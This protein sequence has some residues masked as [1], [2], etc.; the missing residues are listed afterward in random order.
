MTPADVVSRLASRDA[1]RTEADLQADI[2]LLLTSGGL[3]IAPDHVAKLEVPAA[4]G[5]RRRLDV[6]IGHA[7]I[8]VK[9][10]LRAPGVLKDSEVQLAGYVATR[11]SV[12]GTR[13]VGILTDGTDWR[14]YHLAGGE[15][16]LV[17]TLS[18]SAQDPDDERLRGWLE[19]VLATDIEISPSPIE[20]RRRLGAESPAHLLDHATLKA[21]YQKSAGQHEVILKRE[22]WAKLLRTAFG[23]GFEDDEELFIDHTLL[24]LSAE[25]IAHAVVGFDVSRRGSLTPHTL[26]RGTAFADS[27]IYGVVEADFFDWVLDV[28]GGASFITVLA[29]R[30]G[31]FDWSHV[32]HDVLKA[33][34]ES[35]IPAASRAGLGEY[36]TPDWLADRVVESAILEPLEQRVLDPACGSGTFLFHAIRR[37]LLAAEAAGMSPSAA[38]EAVT[39]R[40]IGMDVHPVA[41]TLARVTYLLAIGRDRLSADD[42]SAIN[43]PVYLGD[44]IQWEQ[45]S[46]LLGG[47]DEIS[48]STTGDDLVEGGGGALFGD[49]LVF[50]RSVLSDASQFDRLVTVM[51]ERAREA[52]TKNSRDLILPVLFQLGVHENDTDRLVETFDTMRRLHASGRDHIWGY[53]VRNLIRPLWLSDPANQ[54]DVIVGNPPWLRYAKMT[55]P[56]QVRFKRLSKARGLLS[57][58][59]GAA[60]RDLSTLF[61]VRTIE[62]YLRPTGNFALVMPHGT[63]TRQPHDGF[64]AGSWGS[65]SYG[66]LSVAFDESWDLSKAPTGFPMVSCVIRGSRAPSARRMSAN[67]LEWRSRLRVSTGAWRDVA[68]QF[69]VSPGRVLQQSSESAPEP[70]AYKKRFR[71]GAVLAPI[72]LLFATDAPAGPLGPGAGRVSVESLRTNLEKKPWREVQS[73]HAS[74]ERSFLRDVYLGESV[75]PF[76]TRD[77]RRA[78]LPIRN[79]SIM[80][81]AQV[82]EHDGL[83]QWWRAAEALWA[84]N[85]A[86][87]DSSALLERI[88]FHGQLSAQIPAATHRV[89]YTKAGSN[90][91]AARV[92]DERAIIDFGLYWSAASSESEALYLT[93]ILNSR[94]L[95]ERVKPLQT[96]GLF[97]ARHFDKYVFAIPIPVYSSADAEHRALVE[98]AREAERVASEVDIAGAKHFTTARSMIKD[99]LGSILDEIDSVVLGL[100]PEPLDAVGS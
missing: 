43:I 85:R 16:R 46:D 86:A 30:I 23:K 3:N 24:V 4:D 32:D 40:V 9:K 41:V 96:I 67:V 33:L 36:Y 74:V 18:L 89:V 37:F 69:Q 35:V 93:A 10:D 52:S 48:V 84:A 73:L 91:A 15:L 92:T 61:A 66:P 28:E 81:A 57:G 54:V 64:R 22:L 14:L 72:V 100:V 29:D 70:S 62:L 27:L 39:H 68:D 58:G 25:I 79:D 63:M 7:V 31:R 65:P 20:I 83:R 50:P 97:G 13:Y 59:L 17:A 12:L 55:K 19:A 51:A 47:L 5:T 56:M 78:V 53:Y 88:D 87:S 80:T 26:A 71:Q 45:H 42:R 99:R 90:L 94:A 95:L 38:V 8:E 2:Y 49:D 6:E 60:S 21:L 11:S 76:R 75:L 44:S 1:N 98:L 77:P 34:Y 82:E